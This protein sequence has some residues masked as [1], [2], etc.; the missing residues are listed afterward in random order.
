MCLDY[1]DSEQQAERSGMGV[2]AGS[3]V[4]KQVS[5]DTIPY[6]LPQHFPFEEPRVVAHRDFWGAPG[7]IIRVQPPTTTGLR[8]VRLRHS[9]CFRLWCPKAANWHGSNVPHSIEPADL[10]AH[11]WRGHKRN[12]GR[13]QFYDDQGSF[14]SAFN[15]PREPLCSCRH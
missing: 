1:H 3:S 8:G 13:L 12:K 2:H 10:A 9:R 6:A 5:R 11:V 15:V 14:G 4:S 7:M